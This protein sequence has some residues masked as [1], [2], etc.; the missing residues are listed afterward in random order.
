MGTGESR[1][2]TFDPAVHDL[3]RLPG[4]PPGEPV[5]AQ[6]HQ[7]L[8]GVLEAPRNERDFAQRHHH[9]VRQPIGQRHQPR[10]DGIEIVFV[11][12]QLTDPLLQLFQ[13][14]KSQKDKISNN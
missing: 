6:E 10:A 13:F 4:R 11:L 7:D 1:I 12:A 14:L 5:V 2:L 8:V 9:L 3:Q